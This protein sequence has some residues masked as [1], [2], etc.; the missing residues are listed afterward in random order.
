ML[1]ISAALQM[2]PHAMVMAIVTCAVGFLM[3]QAGL[4]KSA[5]EKR[6]R[7][8]WCPSCGCKRQSC[9]CNRGHRRFRLRG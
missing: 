7:E 9:G 5:L 2:S 6:K 8:K 1:F 4:G 3:T